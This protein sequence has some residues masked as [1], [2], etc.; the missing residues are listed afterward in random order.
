[1]RGRAEVAH[2][3]HNLGV[4]WFESHSRK[5]NNET[6][7]PRGVVRV[8]LNMFRNKAYITIDMG[9]IY[10]ITNK[11]NQKKYI[12]KTTFSVEKRWNEHLNDY[13][14]KHLEKRALYEAMNKYGANNFICEELCE[15]SNDIL[16]IKEQEYIELFQTYHYGYNLTIGGDG[17]ILYNYKD[18]IEYYLNNKVT[19][20]DTAKYF[21]CSTDT[22]K[23]VLVKYNV[24]IRNLHKE[25]FYGSC[26]K[27]KEIFCFTK[28][29]EF[30][31]QFCSVKEASEWIFENGKC[32]TINSGVRGHISDCANGKITTAYGY[33]WKYN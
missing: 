19:I 24:K 15:C 21:N 25:N 12:G 29:N 2:Q 17:K 6:L 14:R 31:K 1:M 33:I 4:V 28:E 10:C 9:F 5:N 20:K 26:L 32:K 23:D 3:A 27:P 7:P 13:K 8:T 30:V 18:I 16:D 11:I 22:I